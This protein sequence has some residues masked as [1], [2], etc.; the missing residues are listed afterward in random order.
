MTEREF[1]DSIG[2]VYE[3]NKVDCEYCLVANHADICNS[4]ASC[5]DAIR[6]MFYLCVGENNNEKQENRILHHS[7]GDRSTNM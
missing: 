6:M 4:C 3:S 5:G 1:W 2:K 7:T